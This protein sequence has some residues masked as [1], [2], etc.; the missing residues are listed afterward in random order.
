MKLVPKEMYAELE[1]AVGKDYVSQNPA[2]LDGYAWQPIFSLTSQKWIPR[3]AA[4]VLPSTTEEVQAAVRVCNKYKVKF[5]AHS[6]GWAAWGGPSEEG[7]LQIDLRRMNKI[8]ELDEK[9]KFALVEPYVC[10]GQ[11]QAEAMRKGLNC[12]IIGAGPNTSIL[13]STT[14]AWGYGG[15]GLSTGYGGRN[16]LGIEWVLPDG[17]VLKVGSPGSEAGWF[18]GDGPGPSLRGMMRGF[19]G[20]Q[21]SLGVFTKCAVKLYPWYGPREPKVTGVLLDVDAE[22]PPTEKMFWIAAPNFQKY[23]DLTYEIGNAEIAYWFCRSPLGAGVEL[24]TPRAME[25]VFGSSNMRKVLDVCQHLGVAL[26]S[27]VSEREIAYQEKVLRRITLDHD[28]I[29]MD[30]TK[31][32]GYGFWWWTMGVRSILTALTFRAGG[33]FLT[34]YGSPMEYDNAMRQGE[35]AVECKK[36]YIDLGF[37]KDDNSD[38]GWGGI[39]E[40]TA[41]WGHLEMAAMFDRRDGKAEGR[42]QYLEESA[43]TTEE[44]NLGVGLSN[45]PPGAWKVY[46]PKIHNYHLWQAKIKKALDPNATADYEWYVP[47]ID[48]IEE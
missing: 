5:K 36:K 47:P 18:S 42:A 25:K 23:A 29:L 2:V 1:E 16:P 3:P 31:V 20:T 21:G 26:L 35:V 22:V 39:Y 44:H 37:F 46:G 10:C 15:T 38:I 40:G 14:S 13:A 6:T 24:F 33:D 28:C 45:L 30:L 9:N 48:Q 17:E 32:P 41:N 12:H 8:I 19:A 27:S 4:V 34:S 7:E 11:L 43:R